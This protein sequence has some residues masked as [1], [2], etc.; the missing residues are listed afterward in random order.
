[1]R[2][3]TEATLILTL[4]VVL[5]LLIMGVIFPR[6]ALGGGAPA[7]Q[8]SAIVPAV[9]VY[10]THNVPDADHPPTKPGTSDRATKSECPYLAAR[11]RA[12]KCPS[13]TDHGAMTA[14]PFLLEKH[15]KELETK[16]PPVKGLGQHT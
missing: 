5:T 9:F 7:I 15:Q 8:S 3:T 1:M 14:C 10:G 12:L 4:S 13:A 2:S 6:H 16:T 11:A